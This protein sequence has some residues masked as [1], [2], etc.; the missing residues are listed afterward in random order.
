MMGKTTATPRLQNTLWKRRLQQWKHK[1]NDLLHFSLRHTRR[2][3]WRQLPLSL[4]LSLSHALSL[5][6]R[7]TTNFRKCNNN[8]LS[9]CPKSYLYI[10]DFWVICTCVPSNRSGRIGT[11]SSV[12][13]FSLTSIRRDLFSNTIVL[14]LPWFE[15]HN[16]DIDWRTREIHYGKARGSTHEIATFRYINCEK[17]DAMKKCF[18]SQYQ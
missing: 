18:S 12:I 8:I 5:H 16:P 13:R 6:T 2:L 9:V 17:K 11:G 4:S 10:Y 1:G 15:L 7:Y 14:G 3:Q